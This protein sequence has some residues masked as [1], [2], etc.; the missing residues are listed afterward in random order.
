MNRKKNS[1]IT[2][3]TLLALGG[4]SS[5]QNPAGNFRC[6]ELAYSAVLSGKETHEDSWQPKAYRQG[7]MMAIRERPP[8]LPAGSRSVI[9][10]P[11]GEMRPGDLNIPS[12]TQPPFP[13]RRIDPAQVDRITEQLEYLLKAV[14]PELTE[15]SK[16][17]LPRDLIPHLK[18]IE[19]LSKK[20]RRQLTP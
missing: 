7:M 3:A 2:L 14:Q 18:R 17:Q 4:A 8:V 6:T 9:G 13:R 1:A 19:K 16:G 11:P 15:A 5:A 10:G 12:Q 20:L